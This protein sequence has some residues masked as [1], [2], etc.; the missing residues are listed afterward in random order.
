[1]NNKE[2]NA[3]LRGVRELGDALRGNGSTVA[4]V[5]R[6]EPGS[7]IAIRAKLRLSQAEFAHQIGR[8]HV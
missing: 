1:M 6:I 3:L 5:D 4:R 7:V 8:A 2:F